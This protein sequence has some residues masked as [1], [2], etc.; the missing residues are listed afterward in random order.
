MLTFA[1]PAFLWGLLGLAAP[2]LIHLINRDLFRPLRFP[3][4]RFILRGKMPVERKRRLRDLLLLALRML[5]F[6][7]IIG[8][9]ARPEWQPRHSAATSSAEA[10]EIVLLLD[11]SASMSGWNSWKQAVNQAEEILSQNKQAAIGLVVSA[12]NPLAAVAPSRDFSEIRQVLGATQPEFVA[13]DHREAFRQAFRL[14]SP[15]K[16]HSLFVISDLQASDWAPTALPRAPADVDLQWINTRTGPR[17]NVGIVNARALPLPEGR[18][19]I[20]AE[21]RNFGEQA[22]SR[23]VR[24]RAGDSTQNQTIQIDPGKIAT[25][26]FILE[27]D[28]AARAVISMEADAYSADDRFHLWL[29][30]PPALKILA[31]VPLTDEPEKTEE[32]FFLSRAL[33]TRTENQWV[34]FNVETTEPA[35]VTAAQL[36]NRHTV[37]LLGAGPYLDDTQWSAIREYASQGG[38]LLITPGKAPARQVALLNEQKIFGLKFHGLTGAG[39][40]GKPHSIGWLAPDSALDLL[41][42]DEA[43]RGLSHVAF[44]RL[45][46]LEAIGE[47][48]S[49]LMRATSDDPLILA[50]P[51]D[52]GQVFVSAFSFDL[53]WT[54]LPLTTAFLP[55]IRELVAGDVPADFG[56]VY[57]DTGTPLSALASRLGVPVENTALSRI[58]P[59]IPGLHMIGGTPLILNIPR[60][61]SLTRAADPIDLASATAP[62][63]S[64]A[65]T[66]STPG[67]DNGGISLWP[68]LALAALLFFIIEMPLAARLRAAAK[69]ATPAG[70]VPSE[71]TLRSP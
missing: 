42:R 58:D 16:E 43:A 15:D 51:L 71:A 19:Q 49:D 34:H 32:L 54:D 64:S 5:L 37:L 52:S 31:I 70:N 57:A 24:L 41:F 38:R 28:E 20:V 18:R 66:A 26:V 7:A 13:G 44:Y 55:M 65:V 2:I 50:R 12:A 68:W 29:A 35:D 69:P 17:E 14:F 39:R 62:S 56:I 60:S 21:L 8:A 46:R 45:A 59:A 63:R 36:E 25:A 61:E 67:I 10:R 23:S 3:S 33:Q 53:E 6:A 30:P 9:L 11:A 22:A 47:K 48:G 1:N 40:Q 27:N 4:I